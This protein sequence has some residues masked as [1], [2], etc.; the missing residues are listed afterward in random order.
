MIPNVTDTGTGWYVRLGYRL[1]TRRKFFSA[2]AYGDRDKALSAA[3]AWRDAR[4]AE[5][6]ELKTRAAWRAAKK[7]RGN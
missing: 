1:M 6:S 3:L 4:L 2:E 7:M 5:L